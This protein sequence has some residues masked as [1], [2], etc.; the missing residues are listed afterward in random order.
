MQ[1]SLIVIIMTIMVVMMVMK[2]F[3]IMMMA[4][5]LTGK[6]TIWLRDWMMIMAMSMVMLIMAMMLIMMTRGV[7]FMRVMMTMTMTRRKKG[8]VWMR[9][10]TTMRTADPQAV[11]PSYLFLYLQTAALYM[12]NDRSKKLYLNQTL[13]QYRFIQHSNT[14]LPLCP[15]NFSVNG[16]LYRVQCRKITRDDS[17]RELWPMQSTMWKTWACH[18]AG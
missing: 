10:E 9:G 4:S 5:W 3:T 14:A 7:I 17:W 15:T 12:D 1:V 6:L 2:V 11:H 8:R 18:L 16:K 13:N